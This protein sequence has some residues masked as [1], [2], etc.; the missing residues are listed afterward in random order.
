MGYSYI[1]LKES[2]NHRLDFLEYL[3]VLFNKSFAE[4][5][6]IKFNSTIQDALLEVRAACLEARAFEDILREHDAKEMERK[7]L[8][9]ALTGKVAD[10]IAETAAAFG[11]G[12]G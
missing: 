11:K 12:I 8:V 5:N 10:S 3:C 1:G 9:S 6:S 2:K 4:L 7:E